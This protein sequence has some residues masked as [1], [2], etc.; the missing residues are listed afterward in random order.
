[1]KS[2]VAFGGGNVRCRGLGHSPTRPQVK[3]Q[4]QANPRVHGVQGQE[5]GKPINVGNVDLSCKE[6]R[7]WKSTQRVDEVNALV[8]W[9]GFLTLFYQKYFP[10]TLHDKKEQE[11]LTLTQGDDMSILD[12]ETKFNELSQFVGAI[13]DDDVKK[14]K[15]DVIYAGG[16]TLGKL[17]Q[18][19]MELPSNVVR[20]VKYGKTGLL[21]IS[22]YSGSGGRVLKCVEGTLGMNRVTNAPTKSPLSTSQGKQRHQKPNTQGMLY[23]TNQRDAQASNDVATGILPISS[24]LAYV[25]F[26]HSFISITYSMKCNVPSEPL[27][28]EVVFDT[29][30]GGCLLGSR[31]GKSCVIEIEGQNIEVDLTLSNLK[32]FDV[33]LGM[34]WLASQYP[35]LD[36]R[37]KMVYFT[38]PRKQKIE[39]CRSKVVSPPR[40]V[41]AI[42][43][44]GMLRKG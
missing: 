25:L 1:M 14:E 44:H 35:S 17:V 19:R 3:P 36:C 43:A 23:A 32:D 9:L 40:I 22:C 10:D 4:A 37:E 26:D 2:R 21:A 15:S 7:W 29:P 13:V 34:D 39:Y 8:T 27:D 31:F 28:I 42:E 11:F 30:V 16:H 41:F 5:L 18:G 24:T 12:Y 6:E 20:S 38:I 33:I